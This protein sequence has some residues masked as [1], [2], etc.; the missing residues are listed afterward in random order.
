MS[1][2]VS[3]QQA[4]TRVHT[5]ARHLLPQQ[6]SSSSS[7]PFAHQVVDEHP[8]AEP[9]DELREFDQYKGI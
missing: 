5:I 3:S 9:S 1:C 2:P 6:A 4:Q 7:C 8:Q